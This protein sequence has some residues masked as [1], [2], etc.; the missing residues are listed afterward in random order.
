M[1]E[2][3]LILKSRKPAA[4]SD[5]RQRL[6]AFSFGSTDGTKSFVR[7]LASENGWTEEYTH[8]V[9]EEYRRFLFLTAVA[10]HV[11][12]P[13]EAVDAAWHQHLIYSRSYW[14]DLCEQTLGYPLH[15]DPTAGGPAEARKHWD[16]YRRTLDSY[17]ETFGTEPPRDI[18]P[19]A[20]E[21][22]DPHSQPRQLDLRDYWVFRKPLFWPRQRRRRHMVAAACLPLLAAGLGPLDWRGPS[23]LMLFISLYAAILVISYVVRRH[24]RDVPIQDD[25]ELTP[26]E[27]ACLGYGKTVAVN[28][29]VA[30]MLQ[31]GQLI[32]DRTSGLL[33]TSLGSQVEFLTGAT[34]PPADGSLA[35]EIYKAVE[36]QPQTL[37]QLHQSL[38]G[39]TEILEGRLRSGGY[40]LNAS[41]MLPA[42]LIPAFALF[43]LLVLGGCK[44]A[45]GMQ[46][47]RPVEFLVFCCIGVLITLFAMFKTARR[48]LAAD[49][50]LDALRAQHSDLRSAVSDRPMIGANV[51]L[52]A[53]LFGATALVGTVLADL[54][55]AWMSAAQSGNYT[56]S[57]CGGTGCG[58]GC[59]GTGCGS[60]CGGGGCGGG[61]C[62]GCGGG[63]D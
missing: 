48:S 27:I 25:R 42:R 24:L 51:A 56:G 53:A 41:Q 20:H 52:G 11:V 12:C 60:G 32:T 54:K 16:M 45:V 62:G 39:E 4:L 3:S 63:G 31:D 18:W 6:A 9:I 5:L 61:G 1:A 50:L 36:T 47:G 17:R 21:R 10:G 34:G 22:F 38:D 59:G 46:R 8:R 14:I 15:H 57:G 49:R 40:L 19:A 29:V 7:R 23:F 37:K 2:S 26:E 44:I 13:S 35:A 58:S 55:S 33:G 30:G 43:C 28:A